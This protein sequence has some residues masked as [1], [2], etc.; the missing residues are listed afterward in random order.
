MDHQH[1]SAPSRAQVS[2]DR[3]LVAAGIIC[4]RDGRTITVR[5]TLA[6]VTGIIRPDGAR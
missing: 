4:R 2:P 3:R 6:G 1:I 5:A